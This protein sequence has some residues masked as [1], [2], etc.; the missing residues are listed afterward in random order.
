[1]P[2]YQ[3]TARDLEP[4]KRLIG[5]PDAQRLLERAVP[6]KRFNPAPVKLEQVPLDLP[7]T[8]QDRNN[9]DG[10]PLADVTELVKK[11]VP[12]VRSLVVRD[13]RMLVAYDKPPTDA[14][15]AKLT[16]L[17]ADKPAFDKL[18]AKRRKEQETP[19]E[20]ELRDTLLKPA[21]DDVEWLKT[22][23]RLQVAKLAAEEGDRPRPP[24]GGG[25]GPR[26]R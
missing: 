16:A 13:G 7:V 4:L 17:A 2:R 5:R 20:D 23:R 14:A 24:R 3:F 18:V 25:T 11:R 26:P 12:G 1:M 9:P 10:L 15:R 22:F 6:V 8:L 21:L 19:D